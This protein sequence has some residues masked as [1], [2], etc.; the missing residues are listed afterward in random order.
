[1]SPA[2]SRGG[3][4]RQGTAPAGG[5]PGV[6]RGEQLLGISAAGRAAARPQGYGGRRRLIAARV[7]CPVARPR[8]GAALTPLADGRACR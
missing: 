7:P 2:P 5:K 4:A 3:Q 8:D 6:A 1:M